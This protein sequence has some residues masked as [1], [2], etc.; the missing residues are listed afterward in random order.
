MAGPMRQV[1]LT[2]VFMFTIQIYSYLP[3]GSPYS[4]KN[5]RVSATT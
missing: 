4:D 3:I 5:A 1:L 2:V